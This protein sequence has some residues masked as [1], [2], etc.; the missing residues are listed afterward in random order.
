M[1]D[2]DCG[3]DTFDLQWLFNFECF[4]FMSNV[5]IKEFTAYCIQTGDFITY[6]I[7]SPIGILASVSNIEAST[8]ATQSLR[9]WFVW[10]DGDMH[11]G[12]FHLLLPTIIPNDNVEILCFSRKIFKYFDF[13]FKK[14]YTY[15]MIYNI[16]PSRISISCCRKNHSQ[17]H[18][19]Q[20]RLFQML[21]A[22]QPA[23]VP[24][25]VPDLAYDYVKDIKRMQEV[26]DSDT[27]KFRLHCKH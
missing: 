1:S 20:S 4:H 18:C 12:E 15:S 5:Y 2:S 26:T 17:S 3:V 27:K 23:L 24:I 7:K 16:A 22:M 8:Y 13:D 10:M 19:A 21:Y 6:Y 9:H 11:L 25:F 14:P